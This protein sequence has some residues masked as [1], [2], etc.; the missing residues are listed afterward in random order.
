MPYALDLVCLPLHLQGKVKI[1]RHNLYVGSAYLGCG[2]L[3]SYQLR[4]FNHAG[5]GYVGK[6][7]SGQLRVFTFDSLS[8]TYPG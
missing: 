8:R 6:L 1:H 4:Y 7:L 5:L 2:Y 3:G